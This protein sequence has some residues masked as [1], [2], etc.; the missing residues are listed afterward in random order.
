MLSGLLNFPELARYEDIP[1][2]N[3]IMAYR[4]TIVISASTQLSENWIFLFFRIWNFSTTDDDALITNEGNYRKDDDSVSDRNK[5]SINIKY[6][7]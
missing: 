5:N 6:F 1:I 7:Q 4:A 3:K 2:N